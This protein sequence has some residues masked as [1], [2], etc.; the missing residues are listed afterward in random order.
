MFGRL[1]ALFVLALL[2]G[3]VLWQYRAQYAVLEKH[4]QQQ[5][6][7]AAVQANQPQLQ[8]EQSARARF[9]A[10]GLDAHPGAKSK[11]HFSA[12]LNQCY[13]LMEDRHSSTGTDWKNLTL[14]DADGKVFASY[15][16]HSDS[17]SPGAVISP[18]TCEVTLP[19]GQHRDCGSEDEFTALVGA[20][21]R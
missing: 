6:E 10:L 20:Y 4:H 14:Y 18:Y 11:G 9:Q 8:C 15:G 19:S 7:V 2:A 13:E 1:I 17:D 21:M 5:Q 16:W 12:A 3:V